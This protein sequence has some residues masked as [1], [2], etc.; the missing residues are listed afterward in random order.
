VIK[1][2]FTGSR[3]IVALAVFATF[4]GSVV[5]LVLSAISVLRIVWVEASNFSVERHTSSHV[6]HLGV[7]F[8]E[9]TDTIL[10]GTVM[11]IVS[12]G[13]YQ[14]FIDQTIPV[15]RWL[16]VH[17]LTELKRDLLGVTVVLLGVTFLGEVVDWDTQQDPSGILYLGAAIALVAAALGLF[18]WI[19]PRDSQ[20]EEPPPEHTP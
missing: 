2:L 15:P 3:F 16:R 1:T 4:V 19:S 13:L 20:L 14:L 6:D 5:L 17:D 8:I 10:L 12:L 7:Q 18:L 9:I 11:Y